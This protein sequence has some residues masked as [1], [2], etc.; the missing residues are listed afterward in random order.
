MGTDFLK[1]IVDHKHEEV[2]EAKRK[3]AQGD[4]QREAFSIKGK[5]PFLENLKQ[6]EDKVNSFLSAI[7]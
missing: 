6:E 5:R 4:L 3:R 1:I 2:A 7:Q